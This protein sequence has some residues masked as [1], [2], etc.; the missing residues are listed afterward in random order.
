MCIYVITED[1]LACFHPVTNTVSVCT[2]KKVFLVKLLMFWIL[3]GKCVLWLLHVV[4][5]V[6]YR[7]SFCGYMRSTVRLWWSFY[8]F[9]NRYWLINIW[10]RHISYCCLLPVMCL[11]HRYCSSWSCKISLLLPQLGY[12]NPKCVL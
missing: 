8:D 1:A 10:C 7:N 3:T 4:S 12:G 9:P 6:S 5:D 2:L 11:I